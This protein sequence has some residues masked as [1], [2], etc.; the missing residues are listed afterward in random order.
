MGL[1]LKVVAWSTRY[2]KPYDDEL[3]FSPYAEF[4]KNEV[5]DV[6]GERMM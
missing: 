6:V 1:V 5:I 3:V 4:P 2:C